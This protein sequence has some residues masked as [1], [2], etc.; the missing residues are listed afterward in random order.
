MNSILKF[1]DYI[2]SSHISKWHMHIL[3]IL[4]IILLI[5]SGIG[6]VPGIMEHPQ[7]TSNLD[8]DF[9]SLLFEDKLWLKWSYPLYFAIDFIWAPTLLLALYKYIKRHTYRNEE[10]ESNFWFYLIVVI[11]VGA[12]ISDSIENYYYLFNY[13]YIENLSYFKMGC[14]AIIALTWITIASIKYSSVIISFIK[15][16][17]I[18]LIILVVIGVFLP[19]APQVNSIVVN[20][21]DHP[22]NFLALFLFAPIYAVVLAHYPTYFNI[23]KN[24]RKWYKAENFKFYLFGTIF[25]KYKENY[26]KAIK[27]KTEGYLN[28]M[29]RTLGVIFYVALFYMIGYTSEVNF[30]WSVAMSK[31]TASLLIS[32]IY[33]LYLLRRIKSKWLNKNFMYFYHNLPNFYD[34][35]FIPTAENIEK[36]NANNTDDSGLKDPPE[37]LFTISKYVNHYILL[38]LLT[39]LVH[40]IVFILFYNHH[41]NYTN[42]TAILSLV[43]IVL[44]MV[45]FIYYRTFRS[46]FRFTFYSRKYASKFYYKRVRGVV[47]NSFFVLRSFEV[48]DEEPIKVTTTQIKG[49]IKKILKFFKKN[50][51]EKDYTFFKIFRFLGF[52]MHSNNIFFLQFTIVFGFI[53]TTFFIIINL[54]STITLTYNI[55]AILIILSAFFMYYGV[56]VII[57]KNFIYYKYSKEVYADKNRKKY[58]RLIGIS[59]VILFTLNQLGN[60]SSNNL[61]TLQPIKQSCEIPI[62]LKKYVKEL[63]KDNSPR[64]YIGSYGGGMKANAWTLTVLKELYNKDSLFF[65]KTIGM[66]GA[67]GGT[68]GIINMSAIIRDNPKDPSNWQKKITSISTENFLSLDLSH[69]LGRDLFSHLFIP[70]FC[71]NMAGTDRST[72][73]MTQY[74]KLVHTNESDYKE[75]SYHAY[76]KALYDSYDKAFPILISNTTNVKGNQGMSVSL[77]VKEKSTQESLLYHGADNILNLGIKTLSYYDAASTSNRFPGISPA[78]KIEGL[79]HYNDGGIYENSGLLS[80]YKLFKAVNHIDSITDLDNLKQQNVFINIVNDKNAYIKHIIKTYIGE[81]KVHKISNNTE[82]DAIINSISSTEMMPI[83]IKTELKRLSKKHNKIDF[84]TIYLPHRFTVEDIKSSMGKELLVD[85]YNLAKTNELLYECAKRNNDSIKALIPR[86]KGLTYTPIIEPPMSRVMANEAYQ[87]MRYML[88]HQVTKSTIDSITKHQ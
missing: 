16:A 75:K 4:S 23:D 41:E 85:G 12:F 14:Y 6:R 2:R 55:N 47:V 62:T 20:L 5:I 22:F 25:Y 81:L 45:T 57:M 26:T 77:K 48:T 30:D 39:I 37:S 3:V 17:A 67:S 54:F 49:K 31:V 13:R 34:G 80:V 60:I 84:K 52:G 61:F 40:A 15:S 38:L 79:G 82:I 51:F 18:S 24:N 58:Y 66:S 10:G 71:I 86:K 21:Y 29:L 46:V 11:I 83:F 9:I 42:G 72:L 7:F 8:F 1:W 74:A 33:L 43:C 88:Q 36:I 32:G 56:I 63:P 69:I 78:A 59:I 73:A 35:D 19:E 27:N 64:Y 76:W 44:Q 65:K 70:G 53:N 87:F 68:I 28:F 50:D